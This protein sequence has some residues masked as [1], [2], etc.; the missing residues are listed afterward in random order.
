[1]E[2]LAGGLRARGTEGKVPVVVAVENRGKKPGYLAM[3]VVDNLR[4]DRITHFVQTTIKKEKQL[5]TD[6]FASY[7][8]LSEYGYKLEIR[9]VGDCQNASKKLSWVHS[10]IAYI[11]SMLRGTHHSV[12]RKYLQRYLDEF[13]YRFNRRYWPS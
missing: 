10:L 12:S 2:A 3:K 8:A 9:I 11:K 4:K 7:L 1:M 13:C 6:G 5:I